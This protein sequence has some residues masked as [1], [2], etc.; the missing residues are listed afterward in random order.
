MCDDS[1]IYCS[2]TSHRVDT[3][4]IETYTINGNRETSYFD[5]KFWF[6]SLFEPVGS[7]TLSIVGDGYMMEGLTSACT[8][9]GHQPPRLPAS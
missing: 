6:R 5:R 3:T 4:D 7:M 8:P 9:R 1:T 2:D